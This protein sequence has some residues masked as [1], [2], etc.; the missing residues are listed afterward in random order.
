MKLEDINTGDFLYYTERPYSN[1]ADTLIEVRNV[2]G[3]D[4]AH[5]ICTNWQGEYINETLENWGED[6]PIASH[7]DEKSWN[8]TSYTQ[9]CGDPAKW[10]SENYPLAA[11]EPATSENL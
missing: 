2:D 8:P 10:M 4:M 9:E 1:Y 3:V 7:F 11:T 6:L 5:P